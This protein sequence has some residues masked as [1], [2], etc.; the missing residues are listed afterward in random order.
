MKEKQTCCVQFDQEYPDS[1]Y[2]A[3]VHVYCHITSC[4]KQPVDMCL[5]CIVLTSLWCR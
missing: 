3:I 2:A 4:I 5:S 1:L